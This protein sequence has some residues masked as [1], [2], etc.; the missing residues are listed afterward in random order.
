[1]ASSYFYGICRWIDVGGVM[2]K[3]VEIEVS[4]ESGVDYSDHASEDKPTPEVGDP[5]IWSVIYPKSNDYATMLAGCAPQL[6]PASSD[7]FCFCTRTKGGAVTVCDFTAPPNDR[8]LD[9]LNAYL[10]YWFPHLYTD[11]Q[12]LGLRSDMPRADIVDAISHL[13]NPA[14]HPI[15]RE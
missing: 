12:E 1:M 6:P 15:P 14:V 4:L 11:V 9:D 8:W 13:I 5:V 7:L 2:K 3:S 10:S